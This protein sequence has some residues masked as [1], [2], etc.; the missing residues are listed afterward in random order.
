M[1]QR[2]TAAFSA[3]R[4]FRY[5][6]TRQWDQD[7]PWLTFIMLNPSIADAFVLDPTV[8]RCY[9]RARRAGA[10]GLCV[11]NAYAL[12]S[13]DP[14]GLRRHV[15]PVGEHNDAV[16]AAYVTLLDTMHVVVG[17]GAE[18]VLRRAG[19]DVV[20]LE[21]LRARGVTPMRIGPPTKDGHPRHP[22]YLRS[23]L[24]LEPHNQF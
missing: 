8:T 2:S 11:L 18:P 23:D 7:R 14:A 22:L 21:K 4:E 10:G 5:A 19:R 12:R 16:I 3:N 6:L 24:E 13:T 1:A 17:W 20:V 15:A 9:R